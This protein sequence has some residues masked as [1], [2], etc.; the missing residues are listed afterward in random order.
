MHRFNR[1]NQAATKAYRMAVVVSLPSEP[2]IKCAVTL[3]FRDL[4]EPNTETKRANDEALLFDS[5]L[6]QIGASAALRSGRKKP[7]R[8][9]NKPDAA[10]FAFSRCCAVVVAYPPWARLYALVLVRVK[11]NLTRFFLRLLEQRP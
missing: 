9:S 7:S 11:P 1:V 8:P 4:V 2:M 6:H 5:L 3:R 10:V